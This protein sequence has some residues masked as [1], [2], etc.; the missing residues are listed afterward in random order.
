MGSTVKPSSKR[1]KLS[2]EALSRLWTTATLAHVR[3][4]GRPACPA[5]LELLSPAWPIAAWGLRLTKVQQR[6]FLSEK[7]H[8]PVPI[9]AA[10]DS[11]YPLCRDSREFSWLQLVKSTTVDAAF[12]EEHVSGDVLQEVKDNVVELGV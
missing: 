10:Y 11:T 4:G 6:S 3:P 12:T 8:L 2:R 1:A 9:D 7:P 5:P